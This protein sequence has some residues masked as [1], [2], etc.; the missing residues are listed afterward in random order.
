MKIREVMSTM[1]DVA[2]PD[3]TAQQAAQMM[4][5]LNVGSLPVCDGTHLLGMITDRD[6]AVRMVANGRDPNNTLAEEIMTPGVVYCFDDDDVKEVAKQ[7]AS[8]QI[9]RIP[10]LDH[11][12]QMVGIVSIGDLAVETGKDSMTGKTLEKISKMPGSQ[13][14]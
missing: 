10:V 1:V 5:D 2:R 13:K 14:T 12:K 8:N 11:E 4:R 7:M 6:I 3:S 9:R